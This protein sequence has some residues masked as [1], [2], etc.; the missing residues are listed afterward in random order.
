[1]TKPKLLPEPRKEQTR[2]VDFEVD[3]DR[4]AQ[5][6]LWMT[7]IFAAEVIG[8]LLLNALFGNDDE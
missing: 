7:V 2:A 1:M 4:F 8:N 3:D 6:I 5:G